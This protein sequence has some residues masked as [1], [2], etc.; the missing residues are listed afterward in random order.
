MTA[1]SEGG[2]GFCP[3]LESDWNVGV[4]MPNVLVSS[5]DVAYNKPSLT[6]NGVTHILNVA[7]GL[8]NAFP[9]VSLYTNISNISSRNRNNVHLK[10]YLTLNTSL[11]SYYNV[12]AFST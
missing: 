1:H 5:Q 4:V 3:D 10:R 8:P 6:E 11:C 9:S 2:L 12:K 7:A